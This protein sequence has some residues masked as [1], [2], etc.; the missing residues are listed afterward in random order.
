MENA[1]IYARYSSHNQ[2]EN[3]IEAQVE[4]AKVYAKQH[5]YN[6]VSVYADRAKTG[7][8]DNREEFQKMLRDTDHHSFNVIIVWKVDRFGR[9]REEI[10]LNKYRCK[11]NGVRV[12]YVAENI[13]S[14]PEGVILESVLEGFAEYYSRALSQNTKRGIKNIAMKGE[15]TGGK[16]PYGYRIVNGKYEI[17][18]D[19]A[20]KIKE[21]FKLFNSGLNFSEIARTLDLSYYNI[22]IYLSNKSY[23]DG[24]YRR[25]GAEVEGIIPPIINKKEFDMVQARLSSYTKRK[26][27]NDYPLTGK[28][29]CKVCGKKFVG[30]SCEDSSKYNYYRSTCKCAG[31][32]MRIR[33]CEIEASTHESIA[34]ILNSDDSTKSLATKV[35]KRL[36]EKVKGISSKANKETLLTRRKRLLDAF[37]KGV[38]EMNELSERL[39]ALD[40]TLAKLTH[41]MEVPSAKEIEEFILEFKNVKTTRILIENLVANIIVDPMDGS[42]EIKFG[43]SRFRTD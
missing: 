1:V 7:T 13:T 11:K 22:R 4:A 42:Y 32:L 40:E 6:I 8:N 21:V 3:S 28:I 39:A 41:T 33:K 17:V 9:N 34:Q 26:K 35:H 24:V 37:E 25:A 20:K 23:Y 19:E 14:G 18:P 38:I 30:C 15:Y 29:H 16:P 2:T 31:H 10:A 12:E 43:L 5:K 36:Q 27:P